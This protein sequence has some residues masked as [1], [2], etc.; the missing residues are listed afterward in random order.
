MLFSC[1][2]SL[3]IVICGTLSEILG[4]MQLEPL[5]TIRAYFLNT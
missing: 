5:F 2:K 4:E 1:R 3:C